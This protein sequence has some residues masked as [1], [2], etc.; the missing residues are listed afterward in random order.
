LGRYGSAETPLRC[1]D[2]PHGLSVVKSAY[3]ADDARLC[4]ERHRHRDGERRPRRRS[5][6]KREPQTILRT[7][8]RSIHHELEREQKLNAKSSGW[9]ES[10]CDQSRR[11]AR[12]RPQTDHACFIVKDY[13][14][15]SL[16][17]VYLEDESGAV[18]L[19]SC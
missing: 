16:A 12:D 5:L 15:M 3:L 7:D 6:G 19:P 1:A 2:P 13:A 4:G 11:K 8:A 18:R 14:G 10:P 17:Y 9:D